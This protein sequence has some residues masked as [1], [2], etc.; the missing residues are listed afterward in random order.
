[1]P[2]LFSSFKEC[3]GFSHIIKSQFLRFVIARSD[4][5][6]KLPI[7][8]AT[9]FTPKFISLILILNL[10]IFSCTPIN[11]PKQSQELEKEEV[12]E[13]EEKNIAQL[14]EIKSLESSTKDFA[15]IP[16]KKNISVERFQKKN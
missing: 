14:T 16:L 1:M 2:N 5:S 9:I 15:D 12:L 10:F 11:L 8:V 6:P 13:I 7:G 4:M 3:F